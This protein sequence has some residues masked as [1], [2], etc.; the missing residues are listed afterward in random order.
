MTLDDVTVVIV[1]GPW[2]HADEHWQRLLQRRLPLSRM[3]E[4]LERHKIRRAAHVA[5]LDEAISQV[6]GAVLLAAHCAGVMVAVHWA[7][8]FPRTIMGAL[9]ATPADLEHPLP[10][11]Y[12]SLAQIKENGWLPVPRAPLPFPS[13][14]AASRDDPLG[15][16]ERMQQYASD[17]GS[18]LVDIGDVGHLNPNAGYGD[19]PYALDLLRSLL[20]SPP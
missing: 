13:V 7:Q 15:R 2:D 14:L 11:S 19:W 20:V 9:L 6:E 10:D 1:P 17:W 18:R 5:A 16:V 8:R 3:V 4:P 12:P